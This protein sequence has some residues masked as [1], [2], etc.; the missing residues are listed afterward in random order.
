M[1]V[2]AFLLTVTGIVFSF[3][4]GWFSIVAVPVCLLGLICS[5]VATKLRP[6]EFVTVM[7]V[8]GIL[9]VVL[10]V[11]CMFSLGFSCL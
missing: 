11:V 4:T 2:I 3:L 5:F 6:N 10:S 9:S 1:I 8:V 7:I